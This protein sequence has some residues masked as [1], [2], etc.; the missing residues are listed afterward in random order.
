[1]NNFYIQDNQSLY[2]QYKN[3]YTDHYTELEKELSTLSES[4]MSELG[5]FKP[6]NEANNTLALLIQ[7]E[8]LKLV[9]MEINKN[10]EI[11]N[12]VISSIKQFK[13]IKRKEQDDF[14]DYIKNYSELTYREYKELKNIK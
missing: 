1:M 3:L 4:E 11:I 6:Y 14:Q 5:S 7:Q 9:R 13:S 12:N 2:Q 10:P 8:L